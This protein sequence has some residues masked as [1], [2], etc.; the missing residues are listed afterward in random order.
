MIKKIIIFGTG[1]LLK[2]HFFWIKDS[3]KEKNEYKIEA[4]VSN[5]EESKDFFDIPIINEKELVYDDSYYLHISIGSIKIR[6]DIIKKFYNYNFFTL[7]HPSAIISGG[8][9]IGKG[10]TISPNTIIAGDAIIGDFNFFN[11]NSMISHDCITGKN[12]VFSPGCKIMGWCN[13]GSNNYFGADS[14]MIPKKKIGNLNIIG[15]N[16]TLIDDFKDN[17]LIVGSP[18]KVKIK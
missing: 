12:N 18:A 5:K 13:I 7:V 14:I 15:A 10:C 9:K 17:N 3:I 4:I 6:S 11:F 2:E 1:G 8:A 16:S